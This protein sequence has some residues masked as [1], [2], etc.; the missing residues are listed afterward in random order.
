VLADQRRSTPVRFGVAQKN[1]GRLI[2]SMS[3]RHNLSIES[4]EFSSSFTTN[5][6]KIEASTRTVLRL[7]KVEMAHFFFSANQILHTNEP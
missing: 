3:A 1:P 6:K 5:G 7:R 2:L 4:A